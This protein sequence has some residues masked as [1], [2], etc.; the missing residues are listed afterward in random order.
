MVEER[1][2]TW[3]MKEREGEKKGIVPE[4]KMLLL[5]LSVVLSLVVVVFDNTRH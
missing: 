4:I 3:Y 5:S 2:A 1:G